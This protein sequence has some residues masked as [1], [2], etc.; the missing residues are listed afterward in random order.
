M[1]AAPNRIYHLLQ[2]AAHRLRVQA[3]REALAAAS[4]T[5]AQ[6]AVLFVIE[7][8]PAV[9]QRGIARTLQLRE[10]AVTAMIGR[11]LD[12]EL[13]ARRPSEA[14]GRAVELD[15]TPA[16]RAALGAVRPALERMNAALAEALGADRSAALAAG[17][18]A[19]ASL[20]LASANGRSAAEPAD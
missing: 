17:L 11:L 8:A 2:L 1:S 6:A 9:T 13:I 5:A 14:D 15:L 18:E 4:I 16:G 12:A 20:P 10:S 3:D 19:I 7:G